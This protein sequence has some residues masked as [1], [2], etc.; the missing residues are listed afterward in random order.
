MVR[1]PFGYN[2]PATSNLGVGRWAA[3]PLGH[4]LS[5][6]AGMSY[7]ALVCDRLGLPP[8]AIGG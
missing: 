8:P 7:K 4:V 1:L 6:H 2:L 3:G 5:L